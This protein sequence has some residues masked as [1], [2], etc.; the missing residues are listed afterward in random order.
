MNLIEN[1]KEFLNKRIVPFIV[2]PTGIGKTYLSVLIAKKLPVEIISADSRQVYKYL[3]IGTAKPGLTEIK[4]VKHHLIDI[5]TPDIRFTAG[6]FKR[7]SQ[8]LIKKIRS[9]HKIPFLVGGTGLYFSS[10]IRG[11]ID[12][13]KVDDK[14]KYYLIK[15][16]DIIGQDRM[17]KILERLDYLYSKK[18]HPN[19][20]QRTLRALEVLLGTGKRFSEYRKQDNETNDIFFIDLFLW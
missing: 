6:D 16:W 20:K 19:D 4:K 9:D 2:G 10:L 18:I 13:P 5:I 15:K 1:S 14:T 8:E 11:L 17:F 3:D 12:I 7:R